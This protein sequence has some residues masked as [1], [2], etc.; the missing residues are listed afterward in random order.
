MTDLLLSSNDVYN[1]NKEILT[2]NKYTKE[3]NDLID[4]YLEY[5]ID[6]VGYK[7]R[8]GVVETARFLTINFPYKINCMDNNNYYVAEAYWDDPIG[9]GINTYNK[10]DITNYF[11][12]VILMDNYYLEYGKLTNMW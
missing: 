6:N 12:S 2:C 9:V 10:D 3:E 11:S 5:K 7:T 8:A 1:I 4:K